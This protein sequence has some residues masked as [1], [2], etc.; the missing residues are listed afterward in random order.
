MAVDFRTLIDRNKRNSWLLVILFVLFVVGLAALIGYAVGQQTD[1]MLSIYYALIFG[2]FAL[3]FS[4]GSTLA[5][6]FGGA[7]AILSMSGARPIE[8]SDDPQLYNVVEEMAIAAGVPVPKVYLI[9]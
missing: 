1:G 2:A 6:Y 9:E 3:L 8:K 5:S 4:L 7:S